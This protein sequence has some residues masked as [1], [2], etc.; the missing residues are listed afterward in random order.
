MFYTEKTYN[1][2]DLV[3]NN[4][5]IH[6]N[7]SGCAKEEMDFAEII[8]VAGRAGLEMI[9]ITDHVYE[10]DELPEFIENCNRLKKLRNE[11]NPDIKVLIGGEFSCYKEDD[12]TLNGVDY[13]TEYRLY[14]QNHFHVTGWQQGADGTPESYKEVTKKM[15]HNL[16]ENKAAD[17]IAHPLSGRYLTRALGF[18]PDA[19]GNTWS[20]NEIGDILLEGHQ[21]GCAWELNSGNV[22]SDPQLIKKMFNIGKEIGVV[23]TIGTD[24]HRLVA[25]DT[26]N[27]AQELKRILENG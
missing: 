25:I 15:L 5:H 9:A 11:I 4:L 18:A 14:A 16:F 21:S 27:I 12:Y 22:G 2:N 10:R 1:I 24:A 7:F 20:E 8:R 3:R 13:Q 17:T 23:F 19:V 26:K 6:T